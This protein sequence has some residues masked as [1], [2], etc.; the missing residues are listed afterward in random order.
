MY[1]R[2]VRRVLSRATSIDTMEPF[3]ISC[4]SVAASANTLNPLHKI[5]DEGSH[6]VTE[7]SARLGMGVV[8]SDD[9]E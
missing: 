2:C 4:V 8:A 3:G 6:L 5:D 9:D 7:S 1:T